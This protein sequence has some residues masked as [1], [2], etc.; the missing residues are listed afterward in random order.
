MFLNFWLL[1]ELQHYCGVNLTTLFPDEVADSG[2]AC[3]WETWTRPPMGL[4]PSP[5]QAM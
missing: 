5:Y 3:L 4:K 1:E 2:R